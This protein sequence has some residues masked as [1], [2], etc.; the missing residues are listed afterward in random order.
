MTAREKERRQTGGAEKFQ[1]E[2]RYTYWRWPEN[3]TDAEI[4]SLTEALFASNS[5]VY[6]KKKGA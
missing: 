5:G 1:W 4:F 2:I 6:V 3:E